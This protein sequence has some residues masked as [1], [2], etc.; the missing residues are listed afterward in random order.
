[1]AACSR[2]RAKGRDPQGDLMGRG[3]K[4]GAYP[5]PTNVYKLSNR[6]QGRELSWCVSR[7]TEDSASAVNNI[8]PSENSPKRKPPC[9]SRQAARGWAIQSSS[10]KMLRPM[11][12]SQWLHLQYLLSDSHKG[13]PCLPG[14]KGEMLHEPWAL[15]ASPCS[16]SSSVSH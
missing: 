12:T 14:S 7:S 13:A 1:M 8:F 4:G 3:A 9:D 11:V 15:E 6:N 16:L 5:P 10:R 2:I